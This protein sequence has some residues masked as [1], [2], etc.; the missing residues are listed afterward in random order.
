MDKRGA[1]I[2]LD[3]IW[4]WTH[5]CVFALGHQFTETDPDTFP[6]SDSSY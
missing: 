1:D 6:V 5:A 4:A 3:P 2:I